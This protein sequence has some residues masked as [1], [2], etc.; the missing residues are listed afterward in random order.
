MTLFIATFSTLLAIINPLEALPVFLDLAGRKDDEE[1]RRIARRSCLYA[2]ALMFFFL[3][4]GTLILRVFGIPLSM[5]RIVG[6]IILTRLGFALFA[7]RAAEAAKGHATNGQPAAD[8][9]VAFVPLA[10]PIMVGPGAIATILGMTSLVKRAAFEVVAFI[11]I[12]AAI[13][14]TMVVTYLVLR[15]ARIMLARIGPRGIDA[16]TRIVG[17]FVAAMGMGLIFHG[18]VEAL[19]T[20]GL[21]TAH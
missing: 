20:Y 11:E 6:G 5:V 9:D 12:S 7:S 16:A 2:V 15:S 1:R 14:A 3:I 17:F 10:M 21:A 19:Q 4:F 13:L 8:E 18:V